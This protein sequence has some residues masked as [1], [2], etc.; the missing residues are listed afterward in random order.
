MNTRE[1]FGVSIVIPAYN[2]EQGIRETLEEVESIAS[3]LHIPT[4]VIIVNDGSLDRTAEIVSEFSFVTL[5]S[6]PINIG[7][8]NTLKTG[9][10]Y[11]RFDW[12]CIFDSDGTYP[13][14][15][16]PRLLKEME[17]G[18]DMVIGQ[19][20]NTHDHDVLLK[21]ISRWLF[22]KFASVLSGHSIVDPNSGLRIFK[23]SMVLEFWGYL[24]GTFSFT[25]GLTVI[26]FQKP[27]FVKFLPISYRKRKGKSKVNHFFDSM[28]A[29]QLI[30]QGIS[31]YNP[32]K[33]IILIAN[34]LIFGI[35]LP[36][37]VLASIGVHTLSLYYLAVTC[38]LTIVFALAIVSFVIRASVRDI[39]NDGRHKRGRLEQKGTVFHPVDRTSSVKNT[40]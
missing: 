22:V 5:V 14:D 3:N 7:Y 19:R 26:A 36:A 23:K 20:S 30:L 34:F 17:N 27:Y 1:S 25:T 8:G 4:E 13:I 21:R 24:C 39:H 6:H 11:A 28:L 35:G 9:I 40:P 16:I 38:T 29:I 37:M 32:F 31:Y 15:Q 18:F 10:V 33:V 12:I 2:E